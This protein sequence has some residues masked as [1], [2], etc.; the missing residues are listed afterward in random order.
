MIRAGIFQSQ[1]GSIGASTAAL[2]DITH[3]DLSI[4]AWFDWRLADLGQRLQRLHPFNP[5]L[6]RLAPFLNFRGFWPGFSFNPSLVRLALNLLISRITY[7]APFN[8]SL[9][10]LAP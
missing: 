10:R 6:V 3:I 4:P 9:V 7:V 8:P 5:S 1:L 2:A